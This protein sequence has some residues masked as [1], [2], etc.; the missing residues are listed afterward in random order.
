MNSKFPM[1]SAAHNLEVILAVEPKA[2]LKH[3]L[4]RTVFQTVTR[5]GNPGYKT[6]SHFSS[7]PKAGMVRNR[8]TE[9]RELAM[10]SPLILHSRSP[11]YPV[12]FVPSCAH[13]DW[14]PK[15]L[16]H[17]RF[18][19]RDAAEIVWFAEENRER[20]SSRHWGVFDEW[21]D[22]ADQAEVPNQSG[23]VPLL[24]PSLGFPLKSNPRVRWASRSTC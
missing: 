23:G 14:Q 16:R 12:A 6:R 1:P 24:A 4:R 2:G 7:P 3:Q 9:N 15:S 17:R 8:E 13:R 10:R 20:K 11:F 18:S 5:I 19:N 22:D 21:D